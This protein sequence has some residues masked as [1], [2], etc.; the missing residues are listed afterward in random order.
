MTTL[1]HLALTLCYLSVAVTVLSL[2]LPQKRTRKILSFVIGLFVI[3][4]LISC[5]M[6]STVGFD[7]IQLD[8]AAVPTVN[9]EDFNEA[10]K[11]A[12][13]ENL[14]A[15][16]DELL[17]SEGIE[18]KDIRVSLKISDK[19]RIYA[20]EI[21]IYISEEDLLRKQEIK[22]II[23]GNLSKEPQV[24]VEKEDQ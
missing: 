1:S 13:A 19:G 4:S 6:N 2:F 18:A 15:S 14:V 22:R 10:V 9:A 3:T 11:Q 12:T 5:V 17:R 20:R 7:E 8:D 21:V 23:N 16:I 24:Y